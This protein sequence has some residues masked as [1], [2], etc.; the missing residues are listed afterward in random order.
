VLI[1]EEIEKLPFD[2]RGNYALPIC[3]MEP[4]EAKKRLLEF[5]CGL[6]GAIKR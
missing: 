2:V 1:S 3:H 6:R 5:M 4:Q